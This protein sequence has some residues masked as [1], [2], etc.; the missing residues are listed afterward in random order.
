MARG[1]LGESFWK[2]PGNHQRTSCLA[3]IDPAQFLFCHEK[4]VGLVRSALHDVSVCPRHHRGQSHLTDVMQNPRSV[5]EVIIQGTPF[6]RF[7]RR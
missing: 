7:V 4:I 2:I 6:L 5:G 3:V 1:D